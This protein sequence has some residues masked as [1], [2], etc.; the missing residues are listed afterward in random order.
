MRLAVVGHVEWVEF[1]RVDSVPAPGEIVHALE[2]W[3]EAAGGGAVAAVQLAKLAGSAVLF[4]SLGGDE[5]GRRARTQLADQGVHIRAMADPSPQ[6]RAFCFVDGAGERTITVLGDK[7]RPSGGDTRLPWHELAGMDGVYFVSGDTAALRLA[8]EARVLVATARELPTLRA[9]RVD[10]DVLVGSGEDESE[11]YR[12]AD[13]DPTPGM[14]VTTSGRLGGWARPGG[15]FRPAPVPGPIADAYGCG[16]A[17]A[18]GLTYALARGNPPDDALA[19]AARC[20][21]AV[22][23]GRGP[24]AGQLTAAAL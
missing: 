17:F 13:L 16:D 21:A 22:L 23:T 18:A 1:A 14:V 10:L 19:L 9:A 3:E 5:L 2:T 20:G 24:Y 7:L 4:T 11:L 6:R 15:P 12:P 8:R